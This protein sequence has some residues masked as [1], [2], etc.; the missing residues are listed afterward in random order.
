MTAG[1]KNEY[2]ITPKYVLGA[3]SF[4]VRAESHAEAVEIAQETI[5]KEDWSSEHG[6][7]CY[8]LVTEFRERGK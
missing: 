7:E 3:D 8:L 1:G 4:S 6:W 2:L 5:A